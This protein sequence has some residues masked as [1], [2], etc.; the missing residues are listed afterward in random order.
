MAKLVFPLGLVSILFCLL[1]QN[2][3]VASAVSLTD[4]FVVQDGPD[5]GGCDAYFDQSK[6]TGTLDDWH[7]EIIYSLTD[8]IDQV[9][10]HYS[11]DARIQKAIQTFFGINPKDKDAQ[12]NVKKINDNLRSVHDL[13]NVRKI[14]KGRARGQ[15]VYGLNKNRYLFCGSDFLEEKK[16][17]SVA[18]D[19]QDKEI[20]D[21]KGNPVTIEKV[22]GY[23]KALKDDRAI[24]P[25]WS[26][27]IKEPKG[28]YFS[29]TGKDYCKKNT[30]N[31]ALTAAIKVFTGTPSGRTTLRRTIDM[32]VLCGES[33]ANT[34]SPDSYKLGNAKIKAGTSLADVVPK[35]MTLLH[36]AFHLIFG[37]YDGRNTNIG[38]LEGAD[39]IY[40]LAACIR[41]ARTSRP[42]ARMN[43]ENYVFFVTQMYYLSGKSSGTN[44][45]SDIDKNWN[46]K[47]VKQ[48]SNYVYGAV[49]P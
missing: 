2:V 3:Q 46:F 47:I 10:K 13:F 42:K 43:P 29:T 28:Y 12:K 20:K 7:E 26:G 16:G 39:E 36:E 44:Q 27:G 33:F 25:W 40:D 24:K 23:R 17:D 35:S 6:G 9:D 19:W 32:I 18:R 15:P 48:G 4:I 5:K 45:P 38:F 30:K 49:K 21:S 11:T 1:L 31:L 14:T 41:L 37:V 34:L 8:T 22:P